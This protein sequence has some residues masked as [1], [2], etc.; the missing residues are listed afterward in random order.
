MNLKTAADDNIVT[1][2]WS[3]PTKGNHG[4]PDCDREK[5]FDTKLKLKKISF[6][7]IYCK[8]KIIKIYSHIKKHILING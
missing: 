3:L 2:V 7:R 1:G 4:F 8:E 5:Q 6:I